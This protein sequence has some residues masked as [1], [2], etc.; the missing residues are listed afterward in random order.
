MDA[1]TSV[2]RSGDEPQIFCIS[3]AAT[4]ATAALWF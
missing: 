3:D 4:T 2:Q 1:D